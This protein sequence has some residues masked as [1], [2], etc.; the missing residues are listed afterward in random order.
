MPLLI[1]VRGNGLG[2]QM[3]DGVAEF[4]ILAQQS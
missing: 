2:P 1:L 4:R 3:D